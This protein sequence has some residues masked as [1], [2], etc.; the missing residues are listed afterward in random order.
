MKEFI[1]GQELTVRGTLLRTRDGRAEMQLADGQLIRVPVEHV[2][3]AEEAK[4][5]Q[6]APEN[7]G[8]KRAPEN[9]GEKAKEN[10]GR[11]ADTGKRGA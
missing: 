1:P 4:A 10:G 5:V 6:E 11:A 3:P 7:K 2:T 8:M 9:K